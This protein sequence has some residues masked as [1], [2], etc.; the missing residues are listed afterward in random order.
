MVDVFTHNK[1]R[2]RISKVLG[3]GKLQTFGSLRWPR[4]LTSF[5]EVRR[6]LVWIR[7]GHTKWRRKF[8]ES[9]PLQRICVFSAPTV[10]D[11]V[12]YWDRRYF[13]STNNPCKSII[14]SNFSTYFFTFFTVTFDLVRIVDGSLI[15][16]LSGFFSRFTSTPPSR[17]RPDSRRDTTTH[18]LP[19]LDSLCQGTVPWS[20]PEGS[21]LL[22]LGPIVS[23]LEPLIIFL[24]DF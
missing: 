2:V 8:L 6:T 12:S 23:R 11:F 24:I 5:Y 20:R 21:H 15:R 7:V 18:H 1:E 17:P 10:L 19:F 4:S 14:L 3:C 22:G 9:W 16:S 13:Q